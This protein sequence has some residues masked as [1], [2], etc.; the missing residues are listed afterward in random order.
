MSK[1]DPLTKH[2]TAQPPGVPTTLTFAQLEEIL[3]FPLP[4]SAH[5]RPQWWANE[6]DPDTRHRHCL[7]WLTAG[8]KA[9]PDLRRQVV[10]FT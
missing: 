3:G 6:T 4:H 9:S 1:Y 5:S 8:R 7:S 2:L 10:T